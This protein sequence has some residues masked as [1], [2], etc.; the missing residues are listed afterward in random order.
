MKISEQLE[1][2]ITQ[3]QEICRQLTSE[4]FRLKDDEMLIEGMLHIWADIENQTEELEHM[5]NCLKLISQ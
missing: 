3:K 4:M 1:S 2:I 5:V